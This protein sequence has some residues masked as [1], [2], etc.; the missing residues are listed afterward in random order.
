M[1]FNI[2]SLIFTLTLLFVSKVNT[3]A[4]NQ[5]IP[6]A[7]ENNSKRSYP[8]NI[9]R[10][11]MTEVYSHFDYLVKYLSFEELCNRIG[12][13]ILDN[14]DCH[15]EKR[16][17]KPV[18]AQSIKSTKNLPSDYD[19]YRDIYEAMNS[20]PKTVS[21]ERICRELHHGTMDDMGFCITTTVAPPRQ[22]STAAVTMTTGGTPARLTLSLPPI[23]VTESI[24]NIVP[25]VAPVENYRSPFAKAIPEKFFESN[26]KNS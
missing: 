8:T 3:Y 10:L 22:V 19:E 15:D 25:S 4:I 18:S 23:T 17:D 16:I 12:G 7:T 2:V 11:D 21:F 24:S 9:L 6:S 13:V 20:Y 26:K 1:N 14:G 5:P